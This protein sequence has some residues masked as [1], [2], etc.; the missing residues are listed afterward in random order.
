MLAFELFRFGLWMMGIR[1]Q[2]IEPLRSSVAVT[3]GYKFS[4]GSTLLHDNPLRMRI[5]DTTWSVK[6]VYSP[7]PITHAESVQRVSVSVELDPR[8]IAA[9]E[10]S[11]SA[12]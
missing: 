4:V 12:R 1:Q 5:G 8:V 2:R 6:G 10:R 3:L 11:E 7:C 9:S